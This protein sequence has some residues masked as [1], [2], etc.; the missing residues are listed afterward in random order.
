MIHAGKIE[1][2]TDLLKEEIYTEEMGHKGNLKRRY[3]AILMD[4]FIIVL[5]ME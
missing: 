1:E 5:V 4:V 3:A 2:L